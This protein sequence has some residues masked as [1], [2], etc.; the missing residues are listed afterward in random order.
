MRLYFFRFVIAIVPVRLV[1]VFFS[2]F[3][4][5][6]AVPEEVVFGSCI[7]QMNVA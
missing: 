4:S 6:P 3:V 7:I 1:E 5:L 2:F